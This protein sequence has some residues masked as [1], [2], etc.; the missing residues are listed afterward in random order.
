MSLKIDVICSQYAF[1]CIF[2]RVVYLRIHFTRRAALIGCV[3]IWEARQIK[4]LE[5]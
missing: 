3:R 2:K 4:Y 1:Y 5:N